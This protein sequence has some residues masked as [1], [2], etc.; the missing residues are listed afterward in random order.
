MSRK[1]ALQIEN[2][3]ALIISGLI[4]L[5]SIIFCLPLILKTRIYSISDV[6]VCINIYFL[7]FTFISH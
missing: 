3:T 4:F 1:F 5:L 7:N 6:M 2:G